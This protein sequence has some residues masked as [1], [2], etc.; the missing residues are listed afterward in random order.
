MLRLRPY[1]LIV[2]VVLFF[3]GWASVFAYGTE[4]WF[5]TLCTVGV[6][7]GAVMILLGVGIPDAINWFNSRFDKQG[8]PDSILES[9]ASAALASMGTA[10]EVVSIG[11][12]ILTLTQDHRVSFRKKGLLGV[13][14]KEAHHYYYLS[15]IVKVK[16]YSDGFHTEVYYDATDDEPAEVITYYYEP[17]EGPSRWLSALVKKQEKPKPESPVIQQVIIKEIV[18]EKEIVKVRTCSHCGNDYNQTDNRC[19]HC[20]GR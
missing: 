15:N 20:G 6:V 19:P 10:G 13:C 16:G 4:G 5:L 7:G 9:S 1:L 3:L 2:G 14:D 11:R 12:G 8:E 17:K 18:K